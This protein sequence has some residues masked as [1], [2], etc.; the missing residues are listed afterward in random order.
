M[1]I[2]LLIKN[3]IIN[4]SKTKISKKIFKIKNSL[5][6]INVARFTEQ[7]NH[8]LLLN[9]L[10][11]IKYKLNFE[12]LLI[13]YGPEKKMLIN[14]IKKNK[15]MKKIKILNYEDNPY[16]FMRLSDVFILTSNFEGLPNVILEALCL[17]KIV[18]S[19]NCP[20]GPKE[21][22]DNGAYGSLIKVNDRENL[23]KTILEINQSKKRYQKIANHGYK[24]LNRFSFSKNMNKYLTLIYKNFKK[25]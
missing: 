24:S 17:K 11:D 14:F 5:K 7:K 20:T 10:N 18:I 13:G 23:S 16:K 1:F 25:I 3:E 19:T 8:L 21:I 22:L 15:L 12:L 9:A 2:T 6:L 4:K